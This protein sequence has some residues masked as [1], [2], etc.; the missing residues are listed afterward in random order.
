MAV[1]RNNTEM[2][3]L[4][5]DRGANMEAADKVTANLSVLLLDYPILHNAMMPS[6]GRTSI[7]YMP[8]V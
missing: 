8:S 6:K 3:G 1:V 4:L 5:L 2:V 7:C